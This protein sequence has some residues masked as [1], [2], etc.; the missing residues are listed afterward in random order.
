MFIFLKWFTNGPRNTSHGFQNNFKNSPYL[1]LVTSVLRWITST[2]LNLFSFSHSFVHFYRECLGLSKRFW[3]I[4]KNK[5]L[6]TLMPRWLLSTFRYRLLSHK[7]SFIF[8]KGFTN[9]PCHTSQGFPNRF[10]KPSKNLKLVI[11][12][13]RWLISKFGYL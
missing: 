8:L 12:V 6:V 4:F 2:L 11:L 9:D 5:K 13:P 10:W 7:I 3:K 1:K